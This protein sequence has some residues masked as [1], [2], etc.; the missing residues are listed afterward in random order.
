MTTANEHP[1]AVIGAGT[2]GSGIAF[3]A[4]AAGH[5]TILIDGHGPALERS[6]ATIAKLLAGQVERGRVTPQAAE[7]IAAN[8]TWTDDVAAASGALLAI[9][10]IVE[11][12]TAKEALFKRLESVL[13]P[14]AVIA[15]NTS[16]L[17]ITA[18]AQ[19]LRHPERFVGLHFFNPVPAMKLVEVVGSDASAPALLD[20]LCALMRS[21][22]KHPVVVRDVPGFIVNRVARPYYAEGFTA[23]G[24]GEA[25]HAVDR[26]LE[27]AGGFRMGP[28]ALSDLIGHDINYAVACSV[29]AAY[30]GKTRFRPSAVQ[31]ALVESGALGRKTGRGFFDYPA[32]TATSGDAAVHAGGDV[33]RS[34]PLIRH[35]AASQL[36]PLLARLAA[37]GVKTSVDPHLDDE[38]L[39]IGSLTVS[40]GD[41]RTLAQRPGLDALIDAQRD[42]HTATALGITARDNKALATLAALFR[43]ANITVVSISDRPGQLVLRTLAQ[44]ANAAFDA[45]ADDVAEAEGIDTAMRLGAN[46]PEG[47]LEWARRT[48]LDRLDHVLGNIAL[49]SGDPLYTPSRGLAAARHGSHP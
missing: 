33:T 43:N 47:P 6:R 45:V 35:S 5:P 15:S 16:S 7:T 38:T 18:L 30:D 8:I 4:A 39:Q 1:V 41:G 32:Q 48:G 34:L 27:Q 22:G 29:H 31:A 14:D 13:A 42:P 10:A 37:V 26:L 44:L 12:V 2:M 23:V 46:H 25:P 3:I 11:D 9:E 36:G 21:W 28:L 24:E 40:L 19:P 49:A 20:R 17:S